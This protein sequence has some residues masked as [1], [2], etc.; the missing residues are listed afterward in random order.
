MSYNEYMKAIFETLCQNYTHDQGLMRALWQEIFD[1][2]SEPHRHYHTMTHLQSL[3]RLLLPF[4]ISVDWHTLLFSLFY[5]DSIYDVPSHTNEQ[6]SALLAQTRL[7]ALKVPPFR[8]EQVTEIILATQNHISH[9]KTTQLFL[10]A[11]LAILGNP[12]SIYA[13][14]LQ[15]IR[16]EYTIFSDTEYQE[17]RINFLEAMLGKPQIF[18]HPMFH[19][20]YEK[21]A[22]ENL[23]NELYNYR[24]KKR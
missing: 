16:Q 11:D 21:Q 20:N 15:Q 2:Y 4:E 10:D 13:N 12:P 6:A 19:K 17:G 24:D 9:N 8:I 18:Y 23:I 1:R 7:H 14:Y 3:Y 22:K 5:H